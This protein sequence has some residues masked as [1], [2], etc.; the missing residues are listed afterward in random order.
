MKT[1]RA[2]ITTAKDAKLRTQSELDAT[3]LRNRTIKDEIAKL[4]G[5]HLLEL[6][7]ARQIAEANRAKAKAV[8][9]APR[10]HAGLRTAFSPPASELWWLGCDDDGADAKPSRAWRRS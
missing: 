1:I 5:L 10:A 3:S 2:L 4:H 8:K 6:A 9:A 7:V